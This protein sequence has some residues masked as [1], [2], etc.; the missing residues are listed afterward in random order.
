MN[1]ERNIWKILG[2]ALAA[3]PIVSFVGLIIITLI[4]ALDNAI[5]KIQ[6]RGHWWV[7]LISAYFLSLIYFLRE[8]KISRNR[9]RK[10][11]VNSLILYW[12]EQLAKQKNPPPSEKEIE[13]V[14]EMFLERVKVWAWFDTDLWN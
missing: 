4:G 14:C 1:K 6:L 13:A 10:K 3:T 12:K 2:L 7:I 8:P 5:T 9:E 11:V